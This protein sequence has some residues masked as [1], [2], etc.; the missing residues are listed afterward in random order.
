[1]VNPPTGTPWGDVSLI[2]SKLDQIHADNQALLAA[3]KGLSVSGV[4][5]TSNGSAISVSPSPWED[6]GVAS[7][8][9]TNSL[10]DESKNWATNM[11]FSGILSVTI[12]GV[13]YTTPMSGNSY[14]TLSFAPLPVDVKPGSPYRIHNVATQVIAGQ[15]RPGIALKD[16]QQLVQFGL[17]LTDQVAMPY[18]IPWVKAPLGLAAHSH[19]YNVNTGIVSPYT[20]L[21]G[22]TLSIIE[23]RSTFNQDMDSWLY[24]DGLL[25][26]NPILAASGM[27][28]SEASIAYY[29]TAIFDPTASSAHTVD[30]DIINR[31]IGNMM[32]GV[33]LTTILEAIGT[34][35]FPTEKDTQ[36][37]FCNTINHVAVTVTTIK[38]QKCGRTYY[39]Y[40]TTRIKRM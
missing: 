21:K 31:G 10:I 2:E 14:N 12:G 26:S 28:N 7:S 13:T 20:I 23:I 9:T 33:T 37:P 39:V 1:M 3:I 6:S 27:A 4:P 38:C 34:P 15:I 25:V 18:I 35:P 36:C 29:S 32:G 16:N 30:L 24:L 11:W 17:T 5:A 22:F 19:V 40:D 8:G